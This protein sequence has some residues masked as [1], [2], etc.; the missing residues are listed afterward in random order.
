MFRKWIYPAALIVA[1]LIAFYAYRKYHVAPRLNLNSLNLTDLQEQP[2]QLGVYK[3]KKL[4]VCF[5]ASWCGNCRV[6]LKEINAV[7]NTVLSDVEVIVIS[8]ESIDKVRAFKERNGYPFIFLK[9]NVPF[10]SIGI[11]S[12]P[13]SYIVNTNFEV[14]KETVGYINWEDPSTAQ[15]LKKLME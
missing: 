13:T 14:M 10:N 12:I 5:S 15:H 9:M 1:I 6:E 7:K 2:A 3:G 8:D 11:N 4:V